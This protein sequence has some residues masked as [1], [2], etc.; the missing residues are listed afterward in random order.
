[1]NTKWTQSRSVSCCHLITPV[2]STWQHSL[3]FIRYFLY[4]NWSSGCEMLMSRTTLY[5]CGRWIQR[6]KMSCALPL[7][8]VTSTQLCLSLSSGVF[9]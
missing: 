2:V 5:V 6:T 1:M 9:H 4:W 8:M 3:Y 7:D